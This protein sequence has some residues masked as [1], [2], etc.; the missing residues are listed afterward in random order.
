MYVQNSL[1][2]RPAPGETTDLGVS[3]GPVW[4]MLYA[5]CWPRFEGTLRSFGSICEKN[6]DIEVY[7]KYKAYQI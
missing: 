3:L 5:A 7:K 4:R 6:P 1:G 2:A